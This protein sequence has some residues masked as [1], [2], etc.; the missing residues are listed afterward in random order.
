MVAPDRLECV[1]RARRVKAAAQPQQGDTTAGIR[2]DRQDQHGPSTAGPAAHLGHA[3]RP[4]G[5]LAALRAQRPTEG[6][7][8]WLKRGR[9]GSGSARTTTRE[10]RPGAGR[11]TRRIQVAQPAPHQVARHGRP[12]RAGHDEAHLGVFWAARR[13]PSGGGAATCTTGRPLRRGYRA[14]GSVAVKS[15][16]GAAWSRPGARRSGR[17]LRAP[18]WSGEPR[19][20][21]G[22]R[23]CACAGGSRGSWP[24]D[25]CSAGRCACSL[26]GSPHPALLASRWFFAWICVRHRASRA[27]GAK[28][29][30]AWAGKAAAGHRRR[31]RGNRVQARA[32][33]RSRVKPRP[34]VG[35]GRGSG[36]PPSQPPGREFQP[37]VVDPQ[38][39]AVAPP[40]LFFFFFFFFFYRH[41]G[42]HNLRDALSTF[43]PLNF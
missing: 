2:L 38:P 40:S 41:A 24:D 16:G 15:H 3:S 29:L 22:R 32:P 1:A 39:L 7:S 21:T 23:G 8:S 43:A 18:P 4:G 42:H 12:D 33:L 19:D 27:T 31:D 17:Q 14:P 11:G 28:A 10:C 9:R 26:V 37:R 6:A 5:S 20:G 36:T 34:P 35:S 25:G 13:A 30:P